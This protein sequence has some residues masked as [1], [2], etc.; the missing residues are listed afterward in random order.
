MLRC[1][2]GK[3]EVTSNAATIAKGL[4]VITFRGYLM[5]GTFVQ[6]RSE[7]KRRLKGGGGLKARPHGAQRFT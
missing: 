7:Q 3:A 1:W 4:F 6:A 5:G 2:A